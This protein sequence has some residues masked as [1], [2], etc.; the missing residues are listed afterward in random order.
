MTQAERTQYVRHYTA[1]NPKAPVAY[2]LTTTSLI[3]KYTIL[4]D[5]PLTALPFMWRIL[6]ALCYPARKVD[7]DHSHRA[8]A[9]NTWHRYLLTRGAFASHGSQYTWDRYLY[10]VLSRYVWFNDLKRLPHVSDSQ[11]GR[12]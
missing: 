11:Q 5:L 6:E 4:G 9:A 8:L 3:R 1:T 12:A 7:P 10:M 2:S